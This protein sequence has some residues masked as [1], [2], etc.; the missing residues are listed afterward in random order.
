MPVEVPAEALDAIVGAYSGSPRDVLGPHAGGD[1]RV[2]IRAFHPGLER[3]AVVSG[4]KQYPMKRLHDEGLYEVSLPGAWPGLDYHFEALRADGEAL[5]F[6]DPYAFAPLLSDYDLH[7]YGEG[8]LHYSYEKL[9]AQM[10]EVEGVHGVNFAVWAPNAYRVSVIGDFNDWDVRVHQMQP[11]A[12]S[13]IWEIF[14]PGAEPGMHYK[15]DI[16]SH[17]QDYHGIKADPYGFSM[18]VRPETASIVYDQYRYDWR[19][20]GWMAARAEGSLL[21]KPLV[22]LRDAPGVLA[23]QRRRQTS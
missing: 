15:Y 18:E 17:N 6:A 22:D 11:N 16:R 12:Q 19:D 20:E 14:I 3:I 4:G 21:E 5:T 2:T 13:G 9:G 23:A 7:L 1:G 8:H 10:R